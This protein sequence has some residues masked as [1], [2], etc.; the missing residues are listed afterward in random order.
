M[1]VSSPQEAGEITL[2]HQQGVYPTSVL[3]NHHHLHHLH[4]QHTQQDFTY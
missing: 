1:F 3:P 4:H 2:A